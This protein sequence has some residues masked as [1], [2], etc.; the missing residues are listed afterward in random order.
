MAN[1]SWTESNERHTAGMDQDSESKTRDTS[2]TIDL[3]IISSAMCPTDTVARKPPAFQFF[4]NAGF[5]DEL[6][7]ID[8]RNFL[9]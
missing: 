9:V 5:A 1:M 8:D 7:E 4:F 6:H 2:H 3:W